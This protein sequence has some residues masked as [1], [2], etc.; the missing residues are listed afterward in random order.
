MS[1]RNLS[2]IARAEA[3]DQ[4]GS[5]EQLDQ[6][7]VV[8]RPSSWILLVVACLLLA[9]CVA[10]GFLGRLPDLVEGEGVMAPSGTEPIEIDSPSAEG[11]VVELI[12]PAYQPVRKGDP[13]VR[14]HNRDL[15]LAVENARSRVA[16]LED[17]D[18]RLTA[19]EDEILAR[20]KQARDA[21]LAAAAETTEQTTRLRGLYETELAD[22]KSLVEDQLVPRS[23]LVQT[24]Q[25]Y[26]EVLQQLTR[27]DTI[28]AEANEQYFSLAS[29]IDQER[30]A[31]ASRLAE[32][33]D[34]LAAARTRLETSTVVLAP[35]DGVVLDHVVDLGSRVG[36]G[37]TVTS[38]R[39]HGDDT[40]EL[41]ATV[42]VPYG[43]GRRIEPGMPARLSLPFVQ[44]SRHGYI[45]GEVTSVS[46]FVAGSSAAVR[47]G[48]RE[49]A[50]R[51]AETLGP[52]LEVDVRI[53]RDASTPTGWKW[54][55]GRGYDRSIRL[56]ALCGVQVLVREDRPIDLVLPWIKDLLGLDP[57][58]PAVGAAA[59]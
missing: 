7:L 54:T 22:L 38:I 19:A 25:A 29:S 32:V 1:Q 9:L 15:E 17:Q 4:L 53:E 26:F 2:R 51:L 39:P 27:Q 8:I 47:L 58:A 35:M 46:T 43:T 36:V 10:W 52:M 50:S 16:M 49:L 21:Q 57:A 48:S 33:R 12:A 45:V 42:F 5:T 59:E 23:Q 37:A 20:Q 28:V 6:R 24:Q 13:L 40:D 18:R 41:V 30:L 55:S 44:P 31:R 3:V 14:L 11:G 56:P 34:T